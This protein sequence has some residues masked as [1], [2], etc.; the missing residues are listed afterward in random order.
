M[1][2]FVSRRP[3]E[4][5][6]LVAALLVA[7]VHPVVAAG[8]S[9]RTS[10]EARARF[11]I[12]VLQLERGEVREAV[13][14][15]EA[16]WEASNHDPAVGA[17]LARAYYALRDLPRADR[18][19]RE[20]LEAN[21]AR[22]DMLLLRARVA[23]ARRDTDGAITFMEAARTNGVANVE[24]E[25]LLAN[26][27][28]EN[29]DTVSALDA[30]ERCLRLDPG[31]P[32]VHVL[33]GELLLEAGRSAEAETAFRRAL[34]LDPENARAIDDLIRLLESERRLEEALPLLERFAAE[35]ERT[36]AVRVRLAEAYLAAGRFDDGIRV[37]EQ[38]G[39][40][41]PRSGEEE[42]MLGRLYFEAGRMQDA[43]R[44]FEGLYTQSGGSPDLAR[45]LGDVSQRAG[46]PAGA[47][48]WFE[49]AIA[50]APEDYRNYLALYFAHETRGDNQTRRVELSARESVS[51]LERA[52]SLAPADDFDAQ[53]MLGMAYS[54]RDSLAAAEQYLS[55]AKSLKPDDRGVLFN[56]ASVYEKR[57]RL[58]DA[59]ALLVELYRAAPDDAAVCNFYGYVLAERK[60]D[61]D[62]A[63]SLVKKALAK[64][65][66]NGYYRDS[67]GWV[68]Y[69]RGD[70]A[71]AVRELE[72]AIR[73]LPED[74]VI[75]EHLGDAYAGLSRYRDALSAYRQ[76]DK[77]QPSRAGLRAKIESTERRVH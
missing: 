42:L 64:E 30:L 74:P 6:V 36:P 2:I 25:R 73:I 48:T 45:I 62:H 12:G 49:R 22:L 69:Q 63:E 55:R 54:A 46:D 77:L 40:D 52:G 38:G 75:L 67:L 7:G 61:L 47:R 57:A 53:F 66:E 11:A 17:C 27:Y 19:A 26:L 76:S 4:C 32:E 44:V 14:S 50:A 59:E 68:Y 21:P 65:P 13:T 10:E 23:Y 37:L 3:F 72:R 1:R 41:A 39:D 60:K 71:A 56:L 9:P 51:L 58:A 70:Y 8:E 31:F 16:A 29:G 33:Y 18:V 43:R 5:L 28:L 20:V 15:L 34:D 35:G 24:T